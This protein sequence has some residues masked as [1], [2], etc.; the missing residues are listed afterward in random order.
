VI[1]CVAKRLLLCDEDPTFDDE[2]EDIRFHMITQTGSDAGALGLDVWIGCTETILA[3]I[4]TN[5]PSGNWLSQSSFICNSP[6]FQVGNT[7]HAVGPDHTMSRCVPA[8]LGKITYGMIWYGA[9][10]GKHRSCRYDEAFSSFTLACHVI[11]HGTRSLIILSS[12]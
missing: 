3:W 4:G 7:C 10:Q 1:Q 8:S 12:S 11:D 5:T 2:E 9:T 6:Y